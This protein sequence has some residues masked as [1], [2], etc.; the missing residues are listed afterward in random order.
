M[1]RRSASA[2]LRPFVSCALAPVLL[3]AGACEDSP[4]LPEVDGPRPEFDA[5]AAHAL[6]VQQVAFGPRVPGTDGHAAQLG[7]MLQRLGDVADTV[8]AD[9]FVHVHTGT[10]DELTLVNVLARF[11][12]EA[13]RRLLFLAHWDTRPTSDAAAT[14]A[15]RALPVPGANDGASGTA[16]LLQVAEHLAATERSLPVGVDLLF[17]DGEDYGPTT[18]DMF[19]GARRYAATR[20]A[21]DAPEYGVLLDMVG[22]TEPRFPVEGY[23]A[24]YAPEIVQKVWGV[25]SRLGYGLYFPLDVGPRIRDDHVPLNQVGLPTVDIIDFE[26][27]P[28][29]AYWHTP[30]DIPQNTSPMSLD[31][32]GELV[33]ELVFSG[34]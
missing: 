7:W 33:L 10:G 11:R 24:E 1:S 22:D 15:E 19:L 23:S 34:G 5:L 14:P 29:N 31:V 32:T 20:A 26:Y 30:D 4:R 3:L 13:D 17:V 9:T 28:D 25:A 27:G 18:D 8:V 16:V 6:L 12:P 21:S 2:R